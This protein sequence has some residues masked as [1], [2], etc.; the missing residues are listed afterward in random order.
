VLKFYLQY[1]CAEIAGAPIRS[2]IISIFTTVM[3]PAYTLVYANPA[4]GHEIFNALSFL[5][6]EERY[7]I[8]G[9][10]KE[11]KQYPLVTIVRAVAWDESKRLFQRLTAENAKSFTRT[12]GKISHSHPAIVAAAALTRIRSYSNFIA[13]FLETMKFFNTFAFDILCY[14]LLCEMAIVGD[15]GGKNPDGYTNSQGIVNFSQ[16]TGRLFAKFCHKIDIPAVFQY[17]HNQVLLLNAS[18]LAILKEIIETSVGTLV[19]EN[20]YDVEILSLTGGGKLLKFDQ[21]VALSPP[22]NIGN[23]KG[24]PLERSKTPEIVVRGLNTKITIPLFIAIAQLRI[25]VLFDDERNLKVIMENFD[26]IHESL[27]LF[28]EF[29]NENSTLIVPKTKESLNSSKIP[30]FHSLVATHGIDV[31]VAWHFLRNYLTL[32]Y[33]D[34]G[35]LSPYDHQGLSLSAKEKHSLVSEVQQLIPKLTFTAEFYTLLWSLKI[36]DIFVPKANYATLLSKMNDPTHKDSIQNEL[37][38]CE[39]RYTKIYN[40][41]FQESNTWFVSKDTKEISFDLFGNLFLPRMKFSTSDAIYCAKFMLLLDKIIPETFVLVK[42]ILSFIKDLKVILRCCSLC[43]ASRIGRFLNTILTELQRRKAS[44]VEYEKEVTG[45]RLEKLD[46]AKFRKITLVMERDLTEVLTSLLSNNNFT[47]IRN[48]INV[49]I[50][51]KNVYPTYKTYAD[52]V[53]KSV[54]VI[55]NYSVKENKEDLKVL[56]ASYLSNYQNHKKT[57]NLLSDA[58]HREDDTHGKKEEPAISLVPVKKDETKE[59]MGMDVEKKK[60][61]TNASEKPS[62]SVIKPKPVETKD[63][64]PIKTSDS[65]IKPKLVE[66]PDPNSEKVSNIRTSSSKTP[67]TKGDS[68]DTKEKGEIKESE[69]TKRE[70]RTNETRNKPSEEKRS[71]TKKDDSEKKEERGKKSEERDKGKDDRDRADRETRGE[72]GERGERKDDRERDR[73]DRDK[74]SKPRRSNR[75]SQQEKDRDVNKRKEEDQKNSEKKR[76]REGSFEE[77]GRERRGENSKKSRNES[78]SG[79]PSL[80][81]KETYL[82]TV[83]ESQGREKK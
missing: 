64:V 39:A 53:E 71:A 62:S 67:E 29:L 36:S 70:S 57:F 2:E 9:E 65:N 35:Y 83:L 46:Y 73:N 27:L 58:T 55:T 75:E 4:M 56:A 33:S 61:D 77:N 30:T 14:F 20:S 32:V 37:N 74:D 6:F 13:P 69:S 72:R 38:E 42:V 78:P 25:S 49:L 22:S 41:L 48:T 24:K 44:Q 12:I 23:E 76:P 26:R 21:Q 82:R 54:T 10:W 47:E 28:S 31:E 3:L 43:E 68:R 8:Y 11:S 52:K 79:T 18:H 19:H 51:I 50:Q 59:N 17:I 66:K 34:V 16:F 63:R 7:Q 5:P 1:C 45:I 60:S 40:K 80:S 81:D 15:E